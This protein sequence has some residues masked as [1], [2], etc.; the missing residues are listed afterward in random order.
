MEKILKF[1]IIPIVISS[2]ISIFSQD[3]QITV[4]T[5]NIEYSTNTVKIPYKFTNKT[6]REI[7]F[8]DNKNFISLTKCYKISRTQNYYETD[9]TREVSDFIN[10]KPGEETER[11]A[12]IYL[13][14]PCRSMPGGSLSVS[15]SSVITNEDNFY[16]YISEEGSMR[17]VYLN[18][19]T[20][21]ILSKEFTVFDK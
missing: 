8:L 9:T 3:I 10:L 14:W 15:Y 12:V 21:S 17:K 6:D 19:W 11:I 2:F 18:A 20:G 5:S 4:D 13:Y 16:H 7:I 1:V